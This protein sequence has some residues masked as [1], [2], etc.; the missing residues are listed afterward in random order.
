MSKVKGKRDGVDAG[1]RF[2]A[3]MSI[4]GGIRNAAIAARD[5]G[6][7]TVQ[8]FVKN[9]RQWAAPPLDPADVAAWLELIETA[10][11]ET[12]VAHATYLINLAAPDATLRARSRKAL[13][14]ELQRCDAL[15][16]PYLV[17][18]PG[19][20]TDGDADAGLTRVAEAI[21]RIY[22]AQDLRVRLLLESTAG[23]GQTLGRTIEEL[24][25]IFDRAD[26]RAH[27]GICLDTCHLFAAGYDIRDAAVFA[28]LCATIDRLLGIDQVRCWHLND[29]KGA[30]GGRLDRH[31]HI[32]QGAIGSAGF[33]NV[34][35]EPRFVGLP[36]ILE[37]P[38]GEDERG[39]DLDKVNLQ[40]LRRIATTARK[41]R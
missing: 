21:D 8:V 41:K 27:L 40:R 35:G 29:S 4:A 23:Q 3:H 20:A 9:Q 38:K 33:A 7:D 34:L 12:P 30:C 37:T 31:A 10:G 17:V 25:T 22:D 36:M 6:C 18:H 16:I 32:G 13:A 26:A 2:G 39:R 1:H 5:A 14:D 28:E 15:R 19:S 11:L 24:A